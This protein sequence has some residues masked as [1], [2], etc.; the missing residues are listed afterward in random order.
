[1]PTFLGIDPGAKGS[2]CLLDTVT[3]E[4]H[5]MHTPGGLVTSW[6]VYNWVLGAN[7]DHRISAIAIENVHAISKTSAGSSFKF[8]FNVGALH[9]IIGC[10]GIGLEMVQP[11]LW[12]KEC[13]VRFKKG[14]TPAQKKKAVAAVALQL[15]PKADIFGPQGGLLDGRADALMIAHYLSIKYGTTN[16]N[17]VTRA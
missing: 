2:L 5:F 4:Q 11:K 12:Q 17:T 10:T 14:A 7:L 13:G 8:G 16:E 6:E 3:K 1:M 15:Y 9:G